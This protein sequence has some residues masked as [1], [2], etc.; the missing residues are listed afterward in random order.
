MR[1]WL[2]HIV[3]LLTGLSLSAGA[4]AQE[5]DRP[6]MRA[7][8]FVDEDSGLSVNRYNRISEAFR[9]DPDLQARVQEK[10]PQN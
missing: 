10:L 1:R 4:L 8:V 5:D 9:Q 3:I 2:I 6:Q 7:K